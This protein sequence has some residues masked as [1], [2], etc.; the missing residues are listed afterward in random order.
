MYELHDPAVERILASDARR[1]VR[2]RVLLDRDYI[3]IYNVPAF[4]YLR[5]HG[6]AVRWASSRVAITHEKSFVIDRTVAV[7]MTGNFTR[8]Y[9]STSRDFAVVDRN[10]A[11]AAAVRRTFALDWAN[12]SGPAAPGSDLVWSPGSEHALRSLIDSARR[13][14]LVENEEMSATAIIHALEQAAR[15]GVDVD[16]TMTSSS[17]WYAAFDAL[18]RAGVHVHTYSPSAQLYIHAKVIDADRARVFVGSENF[19]VESMQYNRELGLITTSAPIEAAIRATLAGDFA[20][21]RPW[22]A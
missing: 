19:S 3:G 9:Y 12:E 7:I 14:L 8:Q 22:R 17:D 11:D 15:R 6:V 16:V 18:T 21:A 4:S 13:S 20:H 1:G 10:A 5:A 2:V